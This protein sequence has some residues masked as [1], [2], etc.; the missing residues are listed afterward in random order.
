MDG[1][2][3]GPLV[4]ASPG[5]FAAGLLVV[6]I[7]AGGMILGYLADEARMGRRTTWP[8]LPADDI[9]QPPPAEKMEIRR[10]A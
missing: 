1:V 4:F 2:V 8:E 7:A 6:A 9:G 5:I 10:A 3:F